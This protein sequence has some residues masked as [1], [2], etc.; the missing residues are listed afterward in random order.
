MAFLSVINEID[1]A[2]LDFIQQVLR[3]AL[4]DP[5]MYFFSYAGEAGAVWIISAAIMMCFKKSRARGVMILVAMGLSF[6]VGE[7]GLKNIICRPRPFIVNPQMDSLIPPPL[8]YSFPSG[9]SSSSFAAAT[10]IFIKNKKFGIPAFVIAFLIAFSRLYNYVHFPSDVICGSL[11]GVVCAFIIV[12]VF[13]RTGIEKK[14][15][16]NS[17]K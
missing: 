12:V 5:I 17:Q 3:F 1:F 10:V 8:G 9:H 13:R 4:L 15:S 16:V 11:L 6:V 7:F 14:L 2:L